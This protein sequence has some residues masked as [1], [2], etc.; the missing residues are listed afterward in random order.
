[1][2]RRKNAFSKGHFYHVYGRGANRERIFFS[3]NNY[4]YCLELVKKYRQRYGLTV[5]GYCLMPNHYH[6]LLRQD[7][8]VSVSRFVG[9]LFNAYTQALNKEIGRTGTLFEGRFRSVW[10]DQEA[11][12]LH[13][14]R[15]IHANPAKAGLID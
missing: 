1:M 9:T 11:Y 12:L 7:G 6:F 14:C 10:V 13:L 8:E 4:L 3:E 5:I 15:Y 2:P